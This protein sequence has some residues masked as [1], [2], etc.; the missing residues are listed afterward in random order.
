MSRSPEHAALGRAVRE[1]RLQRGMS[2][3]G[4]ADRSDLHRTYVGGIE[5]GERNVSFGNL[6][7]LADALDVRLSDLVARS[8]RLPSPATSRMGPQGR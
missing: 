2:Q 7:R 3:E 1:L 6:L 8:E 4:L 5:R